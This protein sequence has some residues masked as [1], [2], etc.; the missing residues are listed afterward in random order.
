[1]QLRD[2]LAYVQAQAPARQKP[3]AQPILPPSVKLF[4]SKLGPV[5]YAEQFWPLAY[6]HG[7]IALED[8]LNV[9]TLTAE[10]LGPNL[11][12]SDFREAA[13]FDIETSGLS[14]GTGTYAFMIG[15]GTFE[16]FAFRLRQFFLADLASEAAMLAAVAETI[17][18]KTLIVSFNGRTFDLPQLATRFALHRLPPLASEMPHVDLLFPAR[19]LYRR[20]LESCRLGTIEQR[21][22][23]LDRQNDVPGWLIPSLYFD[24]VQRGQAQGLNPVFHHNAL[25]VLSLVTFL[26]HLGSVSGSGAD[27]VADS[28]HSLAL[29]VWDEAQGRAN[30]A[31]RLFSAAW[32]ADPAS[33]AGGE[34]VRRLARIK[35]RSGQW[36]ASERLWQA[37][38]QTATAPRRQLF[39][40]VELAKIFEHRRR[41]FVSALDE[42]EDASQ[43]LTALPR[44]ERPL[45]VT[46]ADLNHRSERL[47]RRLGQHYK[48]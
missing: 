8:A 27:G 15:V 24:Y 4:E 41:D 46:L 25:D 48:T 20:R 39:A 14:G 22:L 29:G 45:T 28:D 31:E 44:H 16:G 47:K 33:D 10:R 6:R 7:A 13:F 21:L 42:V 2:R 18:R 34:A 26:A 38:K 30:H 32:Q 1:M 17:D 37:E 11:M 35:R 43:I 19:R 23:G 40:A 5:F 3:R 12:P 36:Q 9:D